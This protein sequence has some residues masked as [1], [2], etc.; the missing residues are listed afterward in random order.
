MIA[1]LDFSI[2]KKNEHQLLDTIYFLKNYG[3]NYYV[4]L[5]EITHQIGNF[6]LNFGQL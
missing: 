2:E 3:M 4:E 6:T 5:I 1:K